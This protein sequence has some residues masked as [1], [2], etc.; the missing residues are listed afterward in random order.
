MSPNIKNLQ[1][2][3]N[4][5]L[6]ETTN[7]DDAS[8]SPSSSS[9]LGAGAGAAA[10]NDHSLVE[11]PSSKDGNHQR[12]SSQKTKKASSLISSLSTVVNMIESSH[13]SIFGFHEFS[14]SSSQNSSL[15][16]LNKS[17]LVQWAARLSKL[18]SGKK[19]DDCWV[20]AVLMKV[21]VK[22]A[23]QEFLTSY[24]SV[25]AQSLLNNVK[26]CTFINASVY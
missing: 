1:I 25:W 3:L 13:G 19:E 15:Q 24:A 6:L 10:A 22:Y 16:K 23:S 21:S 5:F 20:A 11:Q 7:S 18:A 17:L 9:S 14:D 12:Q 4:H 8:P 2:L 26:V